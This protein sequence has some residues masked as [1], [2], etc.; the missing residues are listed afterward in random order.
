MSRLIT[1]QHPFMKLKT[2]ISGVAVRWVLVIDADTIV[3]VFLV[4]KSDK[5]Y[6]QNMIFDVKLHKAIDISMHKMSQDISNKKYVS[7]TL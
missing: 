5:L 1:M 3:P 2:I 7:Y 6:G 4:S